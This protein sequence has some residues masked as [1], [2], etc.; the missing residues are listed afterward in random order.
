VIGT[1][2][3]LL[4]REKVDGDVEGCETLCDYTLNKFRNER[5]VGYRS[6]RVGEVRI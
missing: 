5:E 4:R 6:I 1:I 2:C 3:R